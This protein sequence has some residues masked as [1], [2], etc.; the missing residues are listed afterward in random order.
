MQKNETLCQYHQER[1]GTLL[2]RLVQ[3]PFNCYQIAM[4]KHGEII[5]K[6]NYDASATEGTT[7]PEDRRLLVGSVTKA[8]TGALLL[9]LL[10]TGEVTLY[11]SV[12]RFIPEWKH[13]EITLLHLMTHTGGFD[14]SSLSV[15]WPDRGARSAYYDAIYAQLRTK[16][17][18]GQVNRY[19]THTFAVLTDVLERVTGQPL[20]EFAQEQLFQPLGMERTTY[21]VH[22]VSDRIAYPLDATTG[23]PAV[24]LSGKDITGDTGLCTTAE[25]LL[26]FGQMVLEGGSFG[27]KRVFAEQTAALMLQEI[28]GDRFGRTPN[29]WIKTA[30]DK[31]GTTNADFHR[32]YSDFH[33][34]RTVGH[35][36]FTGCWFFID[37]AAE[38]AGA[39][40]TNSKKMNQDGRNYKRI[41]NI[42]MT[43]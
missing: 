6:L 11:D 25:D 38:T 23:H 39:I 35:N 27:D 13:E 1:Y 43:L 41:G 17:T 37:P 34:P 16:D 3:E 5:L 15:T 36:G 2:H 14:D 33:S 7:P 4:V 24:E 32:C 26:R 18:P 22:T 9:K 29:F 31:H 28:T 20:E 42:M 8:I 12:S 30:S 19:N 10:E 21:L 40:L